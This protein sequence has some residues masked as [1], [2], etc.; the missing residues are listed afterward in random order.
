MIV[1]VFVIQVILSL[2]RRRSCCCSVISKSELEFYSLC[3]ICDLTRHLSPRKL[4]KSTCVTALPCGLSRPTRK[5]PF[6]FLSTNPTTFFH[7]PG[8]IRFLAPRSHHCVKKCSR[9]LPQHWE[10]LLKTVRECPIAINFRRNDFD[11][12]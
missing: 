11:V 1:I 3:R 4:H 12:A 5:A 8:D 9:A 6:R 7:D 2:H 10:S